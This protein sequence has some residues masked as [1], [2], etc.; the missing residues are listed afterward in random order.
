MIGLLL[1]Y[2]IGKAF[3][4]LA[5][6]HNKSPWGFAIIGIV[7]YYAGSFVGGIIL[8]V[9]G[10]LA[11]SDFVSTTPD[12]LLSLMGVP[13][14]LL[15]CWGLYVILKKNWSKKQAIGSEALDSNLID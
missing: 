4:E 8:G 9:I 14:G 15:F 11:G 1:I 10:I 3:Y 7:C 12:I 6:E 13:F 2:F 5:F